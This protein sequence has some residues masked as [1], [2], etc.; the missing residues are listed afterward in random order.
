MSAWAVAMSFF[1][2]PNWEFRNVAL[3]IVA[4]HLQHGI[5]PTGAPL[6][7]SV[8]QHIRRIGNEIGLP[9]APVEK[10]TF[11]AKVIF[12][13]GIAAAKHI[14]TVKYEF[15]VTEQSHHGRRV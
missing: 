1:V 7:P 15:A 9:D 6:L 12:F 10:L 4:R 13:I 3:S 2:S 14:I 8:E 5:D 11:A